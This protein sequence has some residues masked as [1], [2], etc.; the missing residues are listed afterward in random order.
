MRIQL[1]FAIPT[2]N[3]PE[4][5]LRLLRSIQA[6]S[7]KPSQIIIIDGGEISLNEIVRS[8]P[9][10]NINY[11]ICPTSLTEA[12]NVGIRS[13]FPTITHAGFLD[14]DLVFEKGTL[15]SLFS[16][17]SKAPREIAG[18]GLNITNLVLRGPCNL[19][20]WPFLLSSKNNGMILRSGYNTWYCPV[21]KRLY[22]DWLFGGASVWRREIFNEFRFDEAYEGYAF[23]E[24]VD[25]SYRVSRKYKLVALPEI[26]VK[27]LH[28]PGHRVSGFNFGRMQMLNRY[29]F[30]RK[31]PK[32]SVPL[33]FWSSFGS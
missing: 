32:L 20:K 12:K 30:V 22:V 1:A 6:Q 2:K 21:D 8:F 15:E 27:H 17:W 16:F 11:I 3:R 7:V 28:A 23:M 31:H 18:V 29:H 14:D 4:E 33:F 9:D 25:F 5:I 19:I 13:F 24:D 10:L 26:K